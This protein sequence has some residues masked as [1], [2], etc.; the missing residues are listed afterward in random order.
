[1]P[2]VSVIIPAYNGARY[3]SEAIQSVINQ[4]FKDYEIIVIDDGST[5]N[6]KVI[7]KEYDSKIK[8]FHHSENQG[9]SAAR[10]TG[11]VNS[12]G[13][14]LAF[15]DADDIWLS[16][17]LESQLKMMG[18]FPET[19]LLGCGFYRLD[20]SG[21]IIE[22][23]QGWVNSKRDDLLR[24][25]MIRNVISGSCSGVV[26]KRECFDKVGLFDEDLR[27]SEDRD[28]W[29]RIAKSCEIR[30][31]KEPLVKIRDH[32]NS[33]HKDVDIMKTGQK[34]FYLKH[35]REVGMILR[36]K[37]YSSIYLDAAREYDE[38]SKRFLAFV[39]AFKSLAIYPFKIYPKDDKYQIIIK[40]FLPLYL[41]KTIKE[42]RGKKISLKRKIKVMHIMQTLEI[43]GL[44]NG[45][46]NLV[47]NVNPELFEFSICCIKKEGDL[48]ER[49]KKEVKVLCLWK[50]EGFD[51]LRIFAMA[52]LFSKEKP[53]IV[54]T[55]GWG[56]GLFS[57]VLGA[58]LAGVTIVIH[59]EHGTLYVDKK[60]RILAQKFLFLLVDRIITVSEDLKKQLIRYFKIEPEKVI[61]II[62]GV[63]TGKFQPNPS[64]ALIKRR[65]LN[66]KED[67][68][69]VGSVG[70][71]VSIK[72]YQ[73]LLY[74]AKEVINRLPNVKFML[75]GDGP[76]RR[77]LENLAVTLEIDKNILILGSRSDVAE[78]INTMD[79]FVLTSL[80]EGLSNTILEAMAVGKPIIATDVGGNPEI[81]K[82]GETGLLIQPKNYK[83][84]AESIVNLLSLSNLRKEMGAAARTRIVKK[85]SLQRMAKEYEDIYKHCLNDKNLIFGCEN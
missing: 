58:R 38:A 35:R 28:M 18:E 76:L 84:L 80:S 27:G 39:N 57:G 52:R 69:M 29:F 8:C 62:N 26:I 66:L 73:T 17:K 59:G 68:F 10:N 45:V 11:I 85:F 41:A 24:E 49:L 13:E 47:N 21:N 56:G 1:M 70:R 31:F 33:S 4:V 48:K 16:N 82:D 37:A 42:G 60:R 5:D 79:L 46:I 54:H 75:V 51:I 23:I 43:G 61:A 22:E 34:K 25:L 7:L 44:E 14:Y 72:D 15:L 36:R 12:K 65:E 30:F 78:L 83:K 20:D 81:V 6:T 77:E 63:D 53:D 55:H 19:G 9:P 67:E 40:S 50:K 74:A 71:L 64:S 3:I 2:K 32:R